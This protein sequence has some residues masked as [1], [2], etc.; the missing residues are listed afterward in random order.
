MDPVIIPLVAIIFGIPS[1]AFGTRMI[2]KPIL[3]TYARTREAKYVARADPEREGARDARMA[4]I[5]G[6]LAELRQHVER[7]TAVEA[8]YKEL[9]SAAPEPAAGALPPGT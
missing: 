6:E 9:R 5:E 2:M 8:F 7:L 3:D 1:I 4:E